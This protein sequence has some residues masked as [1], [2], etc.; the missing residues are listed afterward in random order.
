MLGYI[1]ENLALNKP[2]DQI[3][4]YNGLAASRAVDG[5]Q[6]TTACTE[7]SAVHP[8]MSFDLEAAIDVVHVTVI[9]HDNADKGNYRRPHSAQ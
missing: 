7:N 8:W 2:A 5:H 9:N 1:D 6:S 3:S 4:I